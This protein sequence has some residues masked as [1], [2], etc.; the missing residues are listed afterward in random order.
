MLERIMIEKLSE[1]LK[2]EGFEHI[3]SSPS[4][5]S[6]PW[7]FD[8]IA[9]KESEVKAIEIRKGKIVPE[10]V[11]KKISQITEFPK[12]LKIYLA[13]DAEPTKST[14]RLLKNNSIGL[15]LLQ[16]KKIYNVFDSRDFSKKPKKKKPKKE[17]EPF[18]PMHEIWVYPATYQYEKDG[19]TMNKEREKICRIVEKYQKKGIPIFVRLVE[20]DMKDENKFKRKI[21]RN[22]NES[23]IFIGSIGKKFSKY[24]KFEI[25]KA[26]DIIK[27]KMLILI[28]K[29]DMTLDE[30]E[31]DEL[32]TIQRNLKRSKQLEL[33][34]FVQGKTSHPPYSSIDQFEEKVDNFIMKCIDRLFSKNKSKSP[35][36][37]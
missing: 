30:I 18:R 22:L 31:E 1:F 29:K 34:D 11:I 5:E 19:K 15:I 9:E 32:D 33:I 13:F 14:V 25:E 3:L 27:D 23:H 7:S 28:M 17:E 36:S 8:L 20:D 21:V 24:V 35:F 6:L 10:F 2:K 37:F 12:K 26:F 4:L 16:N